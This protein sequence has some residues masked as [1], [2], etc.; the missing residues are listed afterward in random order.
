MRNDI[1][2]SKRTLRVASPAFLGSPTQR[3]IARPNERHERHERNERDENRNWKRI[4]LTGNE[5]PAFL[6]SPTQGYVRPTGRLQIATVADGVRRMLLKLGSVRANHNARAAT[7][8]AA[9]K[10]STPRH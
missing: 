7:R 9:Q 1:D 10:Q 8:T 4:V 2:E 5:S 6:G 3:Y